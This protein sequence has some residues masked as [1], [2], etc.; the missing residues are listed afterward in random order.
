MVDMKIIKA[1]RDL[2]LEQ[3]SRLNAVKR[4]VKSSQIGVTTKAHFDMPAPA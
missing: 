1:G 2:G 4:A 3:L